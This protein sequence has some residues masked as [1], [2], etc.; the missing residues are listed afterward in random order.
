MEYQAVDSDYAL[1]PY[2]S[3]LPH[4]FNWE[5]ADYDQEGGA[6]L[7]PPGMKAMMPKRSAKPHRQ[8]GKDGE[9]QRPHSAP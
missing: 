4:P 9:R 7:R 3:V 5:A 8:E 2:A 1:P 6:V